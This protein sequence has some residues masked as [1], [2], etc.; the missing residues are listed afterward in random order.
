MF[1]RAGLGVRSGSLKPDG[2]LSDGRRLFRV[3]SPFDPRDPSPSALLEDCAT[4]DVQAYS[5]S[6]LAEMRLQHVSNSLAPMLLAQAT[7]TCSAE[8][9]EC[10]TAF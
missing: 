7:A 4:L 3:V 9:R 1:H 6:E 5:P 10:P 8:R 2:Y